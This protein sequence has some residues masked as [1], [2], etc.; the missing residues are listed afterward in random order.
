MAGR[1]A[2]KP[3]QSAT[4][5]PKWPA[6]KVEKWKITRLKPYERNARMHSKTQVEH[7]VTLPDYQGL[8]LVSAPHDN[9]RLNVGRTQTQL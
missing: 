5:T 9:G 4:P 3:K 1:A 8:G 6:D 7:L 2:R